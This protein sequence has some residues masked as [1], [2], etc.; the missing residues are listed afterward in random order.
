M[1]KVKDKKK[2]AMFMVSW[3]IGLISMFSVVAHCWQTTSVVQPY[4]LLSKIALV[5][6]ISLSLPYV[7]DLELQRY[8]LM[9]NITL[10]F[11]CV[12]LLATPY[13]MKYFK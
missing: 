1:E 6:S 10:M 5:I 2:Q 11:I 3:I 9:G 7:W 8:R 4:L 13:V 12:I